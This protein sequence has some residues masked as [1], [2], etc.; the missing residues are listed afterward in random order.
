MLMN[1]YGYGNLDQEEET[2]E[3]EGKPKANNLI[4]LRA[5]AEMKETG[6]AICKSLGIDLP[7][8][9]RICL[10]RLV[11]EGGIPFPMKV[12]SSGDNKR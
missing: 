2:L 1:T 9:F 5:D 10:A 6:I 4:Q 8:Y 11:D 12:A 7:T 3:E